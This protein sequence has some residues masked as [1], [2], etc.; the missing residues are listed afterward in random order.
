M[1][2]V[3][4]DFESSCLVL[5]QICKSSTK[6]EENTCRKCIQ[7][8]EEASDN[9]NCSSQREVALVYHS[10]DGGELN[11]YNDLSAVLLNLRLR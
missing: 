8:K 2:R 6:E 4:F 7:R 9:T 1:A 3:W 5:C 10:A 11:H